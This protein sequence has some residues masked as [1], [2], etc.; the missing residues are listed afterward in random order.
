MEKVEKM[1]MN[2]EYLSSKNRKQRTMDDLQE[3]N[4]NV[5][6]LYEQVGKM[7]E[8]EDDINNTWWGIIETEIAQ[9]LVA[10]RNLR[11]ILHLRRNE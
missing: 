2:K 3:I 10:E 7:H 8:K 1:I 11:I 6:F 4:A 9:L 5:L